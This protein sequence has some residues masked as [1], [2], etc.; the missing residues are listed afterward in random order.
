MPIVF[1]EVKARTS[2]AFGSAIAAVDGRKRTRLRAAAEE[3]LQF[4]APDSKPRF[5]LVCFDGGRMRLHR[6]AF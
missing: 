5:D 2:R 6:N 4:Y 1:V 3:F